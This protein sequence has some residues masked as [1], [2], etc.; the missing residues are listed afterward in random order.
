MDPTTFPN[1][2]MSPTVVLPPVLGPLLKSNV[3]HI[4]P[5]FN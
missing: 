3:L 5:Y 2:F 1:V 4:S